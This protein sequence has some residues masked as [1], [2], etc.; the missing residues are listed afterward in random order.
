MRLIS[1]NAADK[2]GFHKESLFRQSTDLR[3]ILIGECQQ[4]A[5]TLFSL[6]MRT[7]QACQIST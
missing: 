1:K 6:R 4:A 5:D 3:L 2:K 7:E